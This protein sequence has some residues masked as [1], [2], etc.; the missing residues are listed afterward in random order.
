MMLMRLL[1]LKSPEGTDA[2]ERLAGGA[3][4]Y[5]RPDCSH[6]GKM[7]GSSIQERE[8]SLHMMC[9]RND[10]CSAAIALVDDVLW[11][12]PLLGKH[13]EF[14]DFDATYSFGF[15]N[16]HHEVVLL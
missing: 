1:G 2:E 16:E 14:C 5:E 11:E 6:S 12:F 7:K 15:D 13:K 3:G 10:Y 9:S 4:G 8:V